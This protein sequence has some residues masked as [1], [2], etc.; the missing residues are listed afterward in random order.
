MNI[1]DPTKLIVVDLNSGSYAETNI[2]HELFNLEKNPI[3]NYY[4][5]YTPPRDVIAIEKLGAKKNDEYTDGVLVVYVSKRKHSSNREIIAFCLNAR[6]YRTGQPGKELNRIFI[7]NDGQHQVASFTIRSN[8]LFDLRDLYNKFEININAYNKMMFRKQRF[9]AGKY[10]NLEKNIIEYV[11]SI[12]ENS[13]MLDD[14]GDFEQEHIHR[15]EPADSKTIK[16]SVNKP[17]SIINT[18]RGKI[19]AKDSRVSKAALKEAD[20]KCII[21]SSHKTFNTRHKIP[22]ME[23][24][25]LIPCTVGNSEFY[26]QKFNKNIDCLENIVSICP[27]CHRAIHYGDWDS[28]SEKLRVLYQKQHK[29]LE[30]AGIYITEEEL[31][32]LYR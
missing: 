30:A 23:G 10:P 18:N 19:I 2:G 22:Y 14:D 16:E 8:N 21:D 6:V 13:Q 31:F 25:H 32:D 27:N 29:K 4:Y 1:V 9:Y 7:D 28:K 5:G 12:V 26:Y 11:E 17:P 15:A 24:H 20:Y 3:D